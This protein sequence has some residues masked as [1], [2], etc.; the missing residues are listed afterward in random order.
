MSRL[1]SQMAHDD[2][3]IKNQNKNKQTNKKQKQK[4]TTETK[5]KTV[6]VEITN[7]IYTLN[8]GHMT[9]DLLVRSANNARK[10]NKRTFN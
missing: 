5:T 3:I 4:N 7:V 6:R 8:N 1:A 10:L 2:L 9:F